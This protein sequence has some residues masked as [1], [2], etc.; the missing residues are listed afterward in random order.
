MVLLDM[1]DSS[2]QCP[3]GLRQ[4]MYSGK[5]TCSVNSD[6]GACSLATFAGI[7]KYTKVCGKIRAYQVGSPDAFGLVGPIVYDYV[8]G[9]IL[10]YGDPRQHIWTFAAGLDEINHGGSSCPC[11]ST[12]GQLPPAFVGN[13]YF[14]DT[15]SSGRYE[16]GVFYGDD[17]LWDG[18][19][20]GS[21]NEC[22]WDNHNV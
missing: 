13:D 4:R 17:P 2:Q 21:G 20:C 11:L 10:T 1:T 8:D 6:S 3:S 5:R 14:C 9:V 12:R 22:C 19:G 7:V 15:G 16:H 18:A